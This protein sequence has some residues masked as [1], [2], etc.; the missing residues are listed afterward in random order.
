[1]KFASD[2]RRI[3]RVA[4]KGRWT[5]A[6]IAGVIASLLGAIGTQGPKLNVSFDNGDLNASVKM[7]GQDIISSTGTPAIWHMIAGAVVYIAL[8]AIAI[9]VLLFVIG[10]VVKLGYARFNL[11][12]VDRQTNPEIGGMFSYFGFWKTAAC[13]RLLQTVYI[14]LWSLLLVIPGI[15]AGYSY[16]MTEYILAEHPELTASEA[17]ARSKAMM[18]GNRWRLFCMQLSF[19]GWDILSAML[20]FGIGG[21]WLTPYKQAATAAFY[22]EI[23]GTERQIPQPNGVCWDTQ[24]E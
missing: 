2:F 7:F 18:S 5:T 6:V 9:G 13:A 23:T 20:T 12:L 15:I 10:G 8:F 21:L 24:S 19:I 17:I 22:R 16:A 3:A 1:M 11:E 4:L 14:F